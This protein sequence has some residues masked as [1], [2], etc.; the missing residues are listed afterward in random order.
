MSILFRSG[1]FMA[2]FAWSA[3]AADDV[4]SAV[5]GT[6]KAVDKGTKTVVVKVADG[7]EKTF[8]FVG[9]TVAHGGEAVGHGT[10][11]PF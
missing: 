7:S 3:F 2:L 4:V 5:S 8:H 6:V 9:R 10:K 11:T 1:L